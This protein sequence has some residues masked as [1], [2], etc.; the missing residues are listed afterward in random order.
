LAQERII[1]TM[2]IDAII[3]DF[4]GIIIDTETPDFETWR[5]VF[6][7]HD[8]DIG[9]DLW[10]Q[11]VG[12]TIDQPFFDPAAHFQKI[13][14]QTLSR[15]ILTAQR[16]AYFER[17]GTQPVLPGVL[18]LLNYAQ[19]NGIKIGIASNSER[20][21]VVDFGTRAGV[22]HRFECISTRDEVING[23]PAP[24]LY[25]KTAAGLGVRP[26]RCLAIEDSPTGMR[27]A[28]AAGIPVVAVLTPLTA[29]LPRPDG[30]ALVL[31]SLTEYTPEA[32][33]KHFD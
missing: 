31:N 25:L 17:C 9:T 5:D 33:I 6:R 3:F 29:L 4:D 8:L 23:K 30:V 11:R 18:E 10:L 32:L 24:D 22:Y 7:A 26:E 19:A 13:S 1:L 14:G 27:A 21:W 20:P 12:A 15:D 16:A 2:P 28:I